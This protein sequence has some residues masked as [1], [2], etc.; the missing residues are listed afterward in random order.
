MHEIAYAHIN[1]QC[2]HTYSKVG[3][4]EHARKV[5]VKI[6]GKN[7]LF[8]FLFFF[9]CFVFFSFLLSFVIWFR[10]ILIT[11]T[12]SEGSG[13]ASTDLYYSLVHAFLHNLHKVIHP[14]EGGGKRAVRGAVSRKVPIGGYINM[15][16]VHV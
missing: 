11:L 15:Y 3:G 7:V 1:F 9:F 4:M 8:C 12:C 16:I 14:K 2:I 10:G 6:Y 5:K 13:D